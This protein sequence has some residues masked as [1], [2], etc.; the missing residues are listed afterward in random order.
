[1]K[2]IWKGIAVCVVCAGCSDAAL[3]R[4]EENLPDRQMQSLAEYGKHASQLSSAYMKAASEVRTTQDALSFV[5]FAAA[6]ATAY[7]AVDDV[8]NTVLAKRAIAGAAAQQTG[9]R[10]APQSAIKGIYNG[11]KRLNCVA[12]TA[13][14]GEAK[15]KHV[16]EPGSYEAAMAATRGAIRHVQILTRE[17]L[18]REIA[19]FDT[20]LSDF[21]AAAARDAESERERKLSSAPE[22]E[23]YLKYLAKCTD[24][25]DTANPVPGK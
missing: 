20:L 22:L 5:V 4:A 14:I 8:A 9:A 3:D 7:G 6:A 18:V 25:S 15:L 2:A 19:D 21:Q 1:M 10:L 13:A 23:A 16:N 12:T 17:A 24:A 11:A